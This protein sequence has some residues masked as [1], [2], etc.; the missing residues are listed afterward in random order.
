MARGTR[1]YFSASR[2]NWEKENTT[3]DAPWVQDVSH[4]ELLTVFVGWEPE[5]SALL[6]VNLA[7]IIIQ[8]I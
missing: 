8:A 7:I 3:F 1:I 5:V 2:F 6:Q 4:E